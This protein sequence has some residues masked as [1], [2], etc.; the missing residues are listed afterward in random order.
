MRKKL[1]LGLTL[2]G[3]G[4]LGVLTMLTVTIPLDNLPK[5]LTSTFSSQII[6][7]LVL[8]NPT[9]L[10]GIAVLIGTTLYDKVRLTVP[11]ISSIL[12]IEQSQTTFFEQIKYGVFLGLLTGILTTIVG[13]AFKSSIPQAFTDL[14]NKIQ[15][16]TLA[17]FAYG[18]MTEEILMRFGLMT[19]MVWLVFKVTKKRTNATYWT[20]IILAAVLFGIGH[21][22]VVFSVIGHPTVALLTY[23]LLG[24]AIAGIFF[25]WLYWKKGLEAA[26]V[27]HVF[28]HVAMLLGEACLPLT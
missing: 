16:T 21:F 13:L 23:V 1:R 12:K 10:L 5:E 15:V 9:I 6:Q 27:A 25:G 2:F 7:V 19:L 22:P 11:T 3:L 4:F 26:L 14:S 20:G 17:R 28:A 18:G 24:N 8:I